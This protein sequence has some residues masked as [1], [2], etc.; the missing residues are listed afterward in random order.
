M[1][2]E[3]HDP[4]SDDHASSSEARKRPLTAKETEV[5][6]LLAKPSNKEIAHRFT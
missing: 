6:R 4:K 5:L 3:K 1:F 2:A